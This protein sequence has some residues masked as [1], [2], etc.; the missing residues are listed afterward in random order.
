MLKFCLP[1]AFTCTRFVVLHELENEN[2]PLFSSLGSNKAVA[3]THFRHTRFVPSWPMPMSMHCGHVFGGEIPI[4]YN[5]VHVSNSITYD[6]TQYMYM[7]QLHRTPSLAS[8]G[9]CTLY[10]IYIVFHAAIMSIQYYN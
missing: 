3:V 10:T 6:Y 7:G 9:Q 2:S 4:P 1:L 8:Y 5:Y